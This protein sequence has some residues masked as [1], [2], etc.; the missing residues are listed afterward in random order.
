MIDWTQLQQRLAADAL[1]A[2]RATLAAQPQRRCYAVAYYGSYR[3]LDGAIWLPA[4][5]ANSLQALGR[6]RGLEADPQ[7][8]WSEAWNPPDWEWNE[9]G[10]ASAALDAAAA[11]VERAARTGTR[12][13]WLAIERRWM[14]ALVAA[15]RMLQQAL[16]RADLALAP[17]FV[18][19]VHDEQG[20]TALLRDCVGEAAFARLFPDELAQQAERERVLALP[21]HE[22]IA[23]LI[24]CGEHPGGAFDQEQA[25][26]QLCA[27]GAP[28]VPALLARL[29]ARGEWWVAAL[30]GRIGVATP[31]AIAALRRQVER[32]GDA[33]EQAWAARAL[34][35]LGDGEW[36]FEQLGRRPETALAGLCA[37]YRASRDDTR[38]GLDYALLE[39][40]LSAAPKRADAAREALAPGTSYCRLRADE[41]DAALRG[42]A[43]THAFV[44]AHAAAIMG[45]RG[46]GEAA[47]A[48][49]LPALA[50]RIARD[51]DPQVRWFATLSLGDWKREAWPWRA[52]LEAARSDGDERVRAAA[53]AALAE[54]WATAAGAE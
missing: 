29:Q 10:Y 36:L 15:S 33:P 45:D 34:A 9:I 11:T 1:A 40:L 23:V 30:L 54:D 27:I 31:D 22:R 17:G 4:L 52:S 6:E 21:V 12:E 41:I 20:Q 7:A 24:Q 2:V 32:R 13:Q 39:R 43:S 49:L 3:E 26:E 44:R 47:G 37:P 48:R 8:F 51:P 42:L 46:L 5:A 25:R 19:F 35:F 38:A 14:Q 50:E 53:Q 18:A 28:A 16:E